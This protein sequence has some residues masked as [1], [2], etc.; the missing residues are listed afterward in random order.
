VSADLARFGTQAGDDG[1]GR[2]DAQV[3]EGEVYRK[4]PKEIVE[5]YTFV[6]D[7]SWGSK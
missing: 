4:V 1:Y 7:S 3:I 6:N 5:T 2:N